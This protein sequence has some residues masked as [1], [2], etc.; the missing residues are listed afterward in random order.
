MLSMINP[1]YLTYVNDKEQLSKLVDVNINFII[2]FY[3]VT[4]S[5]F[6]S[7]INTVTKRLENKKLVIHEQVTMVCFVD[8]PVKK[9]LTGHNKII[10][11]YTYDNNS[12]SYTYKNVLPKEIYREA[13]SDEREL[14]VRLEKHIM[15]NKYGYDNIQDLF[16]AG[17]ATSFYA[18][19]SRVLFK[20]L[21]IKKAY[22][23]HRYTFNI[24]NLND[25]MVKLLDKYDINELKR[26]I[27]NKV[28]IRLDET[29][30]KRYIDALSELFD[31]DT[32]KVRVNVR[33]D[34]NYVDSINH[35]SSNLIDKDNKDGIK[36]SNNEILNETEIDLLHY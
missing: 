33:A 36:N 9:T 26:Q 13:T 2:D 25:E 28:M 12:N 1:N 16:L 32:N 34:D 30:N 4:N 35:L 5:T 10:E 19:V 21:N 6:R 18:D 8:T 20:E 14:I 24:D 31:T 29:S 11:M 3:D 17:K 27:N 23:A 7:A 22:K 15:K